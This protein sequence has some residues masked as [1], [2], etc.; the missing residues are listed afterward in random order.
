[1]CAK[2]SVSKEKMLQSNDTQQLVTNDDTSSINS[3]TAITSA[4]NVVIGNSSSSEHLLPPS[5]SSTCDVQST[6]GITTTVETT[7]GTTVGTQ[8]YLLSSPSLTSQAMYGINITISNEMT[9]PPPYSPPHSSS[10]LQQLQSQSQSYLPLYN[11]S[12]DTGLTEGQIVYNNIIRS[13]QK[14]ATCLMVIIF[15]IVFGCIL[16]IMKII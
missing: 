12:Q 15:L 3:T 14:R 16:K 1:M 5:Y 11:T 4:S 6:A 2:Y 7:V 8:A 13:I 9:S 10:S